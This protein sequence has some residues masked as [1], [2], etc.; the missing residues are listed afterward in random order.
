MENEENEEI[1]NAVQECLRAHV[2][3][4]PNSIGLTYTALRRNVERKVEDPTFKTDRFVKTLNKLIQKN[5][6]VI[7][8]AIRMG[9][10]TFRPCEP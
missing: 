7:F 9:L 1:E 4:F 8:G 3:E 2:S 6:I 10:V 5:E